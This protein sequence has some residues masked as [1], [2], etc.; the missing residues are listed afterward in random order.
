MIDV[1]FVSELIVAYLHG[2]QNKKLSLDKW[3]ETYETG[4]PDQTRVESTFHTVLGELHAVLP[5]IKESRWRK[6]SDF[7]SL[8]LCFAGKVEK[9]PLSK[10]SRASAS[11]L[12]VKFGEDVDEYIS[13]GKSSRAVVKRYGDAVE[14]AASDLGNRK[15]RSEAL[16]TLLDSVW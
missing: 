16:D 2:P 8:F 10:G 11:K 12:L 1:E 6:K 5:R 9:L 14:K 7:Y 15:A 3:Y 4:F 13:T